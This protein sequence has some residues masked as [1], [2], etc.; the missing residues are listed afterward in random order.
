MTEADTT[1]AELAHIG[2]RASADAAT[3]VLLHRVSRRAESLGDER[4]LGHWLPRRAVSGHPDA[5]G[6]LI[7]DARCWYES[8]C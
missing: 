2:T 8:Y 1:H 7:A 6:V 3:V 4:F 5:R